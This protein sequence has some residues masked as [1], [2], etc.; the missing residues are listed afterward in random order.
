MSSAENF[1]LTIQRSVEI[2]KLEKKDLVTIRKLCNIFVKHFELYI[3]KDF[4][5]PYLGS[6]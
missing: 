6:S 4:I 5:L 3:I 2:M 1:S